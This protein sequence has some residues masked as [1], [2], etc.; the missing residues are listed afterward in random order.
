MPILTQESGATGMNYSFMCRFNCNFAF[1]GDTS[2]NFSMALSRQI[3]NRAS[4]MVPAKSTGIPYRPD[5]VLNS[6]ENHT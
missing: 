4:S 5:A 6:G 2:D 1:W 3:E